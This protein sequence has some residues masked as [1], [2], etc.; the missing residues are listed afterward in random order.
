M[1]PPSQSED[2]ILM[3]VIAGR[4]RDLEDVR[5][6]VAR[7]LERLDW[8]YLLETGRQLG[9]AIGQDLASTLRSLRGEPG[10]P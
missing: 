5:G 1:T 7:S 4:P 9:E 2:L 6:I 8:R 3:K 10:G